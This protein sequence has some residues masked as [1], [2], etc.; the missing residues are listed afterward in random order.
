MKSDRL[1]YSTAGAV[2]LLLMLIGFR[3]FIAA[4]AHVDGSPIDPAIRPVVVLHGAAIA[5][6]FVLFFAQALLITLRNR[7]LHMKLGW[8]VL[9]NGPPGGASLGAGDAF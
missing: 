2:F 3:H 1:F 7:R 9:A 4:G 8:S 6:W 5:A